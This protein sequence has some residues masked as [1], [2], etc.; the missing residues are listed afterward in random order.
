MG[1]RRHYDDNEMPVFKGKSAMKK[2]KVWERE[3]RKKQEQ[4]T[5]KFEKQE[6]HLAQVDSM[7]AKFEKL[8]LI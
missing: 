7:T 8:G 2:W 1:K 3:Q 5:A 6:E 4:L